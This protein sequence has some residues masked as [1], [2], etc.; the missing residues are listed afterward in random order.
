MLNE[1]MNW[2]DYQ[3]QFRSGGEETEERPEGKLS[4]R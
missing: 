1:A 3:D 2:G 4:P